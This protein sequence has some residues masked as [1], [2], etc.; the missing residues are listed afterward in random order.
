MSLMSS[1]WDRR[2]RR[3]SYQVPVGVLDLKAKRVLNMSSINVSRGGMFVDTDE[4]LA[5]G[6]PLMCNVPFGRDQQAMQLRGRVAW[7]R[8]SSSSHGNRPSG[9]GIEFV[10]LTDEESDRLS[11]IVGRNE[12]QSHALSLQLHGMA[13]PIRGE[14]HLTPDGVF[15]RS[16]LPF[17]A[18]E[19]GVEFSF[20]DDDEDVGYQGRI[21][22]VDVYKDPGSAVPRLQVEIELLSEEIPNLADPPNEESLAIERASAGREIDEQESEDRDCEML[23]IDAADTE[24]TTVQSDAIPISIPQMLPIIDA[25]SAKEAVVHAE[26]RSLETERVTSSAYS[27]ARIWPAAAMLVGCTL[28]ILAFALSGDEQDESPV[29]VK[30]TLEDSESRKVLALL[31]PPVQEQVDSEAPLA[32]GGVRAAA[33]A[34]T[35]EAVDEPVAAPEAVAEPVMEAALPPNLIAKIESIGGVKI[36]GEGKTFVI[37]IPIEGSL[38]RAADYRLADPPGI[39]VNLPYAKP[40]AGFHKIVE[41]KHE[42]LRTIW[43]RERLGGLHFRAFFANDAPRCTVRYRAA[44]IVIRCR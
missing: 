1:V 13:S 40:R 8:P 33:A 4:N 25:E 9:V 20:R 6:L 26:A 24:R 34:E 35:H 2:N 32:L 38:E 29:A 42:Q 11:D 3:I 22:A 39:A 18:L 31:E 19:S 10:D 43:V 28:G 27:I 23:E 44:A 36:S 12:E 17:L 5:V 15:F 7:L 16:K 37:R 14:A 30:A 41:P 21:V